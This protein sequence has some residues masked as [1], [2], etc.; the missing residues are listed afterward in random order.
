MPDINFYKQI[1][2]N[3]YLNSLLQRYDSRLWVGPKDTPDGPKFI[4]PS[5]VKLNE[6]VEVT[7]AYSFYYK[8]AFDELNDLDTK[9]WLFDSDQAVEFSRL[10]MNPAQEDGSEAISPFPRFYMEFTTPLVGVVDQEPGYQDATV[11]LIFRENYSSV[12]NDD[13]LVETDITDLTLSAVT[14]FLRTFDDSDSTSYSDR[15]FKLHLPTGQA[16]V[17]PM[18]TTDLA[19]DDG[20]GYENK[21]MIDRSDLIDYPRYTQPTVLGNTNEAMRSENTEQRQPLSDIS[22][23]LPEEWLEPD[24]LFK[25]YPAGVAIKGMED[26]KIGYWETITQQYCDMLIW[27][28]MYIQSKQIETITMM[29]QRSERRRLQKKGETPLPWHILRINPKLTVNLNQTD[30]GQSGAIH[31][32]IYDVKA[33]WRKQTI[34]Y[35]PDRQFSKKV[36]QYIPSHKR[37]LR[38]EIYVPRTY[39]VEE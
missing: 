19:T 15:T 37:G 14:F 32:H 22:S 35:G 31:G 25:F 29:P 10:G 21:G 8:E 11:A 9:R 6:Y 36:T 34:R 4:V 13:I 5:G 27:I 39:K 3:S 33:H 20:S 17:S 38:N 30:G 12:L 26:R 18:L 2:N 16:W 28:L 7:E 24:N 1:T 23:E